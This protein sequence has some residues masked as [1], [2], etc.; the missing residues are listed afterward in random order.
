MRYQLTVAVMVEP[1]LNAVDKKAFFHHASDIF[2]GHSR[3][4]VREPERSVE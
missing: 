1:V 4:L 2:H 3:G